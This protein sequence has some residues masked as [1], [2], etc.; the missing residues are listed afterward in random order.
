MASDLDLRGQPVSP[1][2]PDLALRVQ[3]I[4]DKP[5]PSP[6]QQWGRDQARQSSWA[7]CPGIA[8]VEAH[9]SGDV[10][11]EV[12]EDLD[13]D[14]LRFVAVTIALPLALQQ[15]PGLMLEASAVRWHGQ[16][17][18]ICGRG[19]CGKST[20]AA[21]MADLGAE[22]LADSHCLLTQGESG[23]L[24]L[25][26]ALPHVRLWPAQSQLLGTEW[27]APVTLRPGLGKRLFVVPERFAADPSPVSGLIVLRRGVDAQFRH[28]R[29][30][31]TECLQALAA[32]G[33][34]LV[35]SVTPAQTA[36][37]FRIMTKLA[38]LPICHL[39]QWPRWGQNE[40]ET[41]SRL[42]ELLAEQDW[43][44]TA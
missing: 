5:A 25:G 43:G 30:P 21:L 38:A 42:L 40:L 41:R 32:A 18:I 4:R 6:T 16:V 3:R 28:H 19:Y 44:V 29:L 9:D 31:V 37:R 24:L 2:Q 14:S 1:G 34:R 11:I 10:L 23:E 13:S 36:L 20:L 22:L 27:P 39:L 7:L 12:D 15:R 26:P 35:C 17:L 8:R 33:S